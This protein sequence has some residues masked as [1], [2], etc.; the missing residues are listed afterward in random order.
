MREETTMSNVEIINTGAPVGAQIKG[1]D[2]TDLSPAT[3][4]EIESALDTHGMIFFRGQNLTPSQQVA[5]STE[6]G[7]Q[8]TYDPNGPFRL[9]GFPEILVLSNIYEN[10]KPIGLIEAGQYWHSDLS[11][12]NEPPRYAVLQAVK[13]PRN[14]NGE[15]VG[16]TQFV[17]SVHGFESLP[18]DIK[19]T[20][21]PL[22]ARHRN[23]K[24][25]ATREKFASEYDRATDEYVDHPIV[26]T[27]PRTGKKCL[28][29]NETYTESILGV[30]ESE[31]RELLTYLCNHITDEQGRYKHRW[32]DGDLLI[33]DDCLVQ[34]FATPNYNREQK[35]CMYRTTVAGSRPF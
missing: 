9:Q 11:F 4:N 30:D 34:H 8:M 27:H 22:K 15:A 10:E 6:L 5:L 24:R 29:V 14:E 31:S 16:E 20:I 17:S 21:L 33:W 12:T 23:F 13:I 1:L 2:F 32:T 7:P 19:K 26:R 28:Y 35:R 3:I 25:S 18:D